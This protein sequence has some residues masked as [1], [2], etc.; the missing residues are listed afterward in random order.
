M[1]MEMLLRGP[2]MI[3]MEINLADKIL[4]MNILL[5]VSKHMFNLMN[6]IISIILRI[7]E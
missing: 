3:K 5:R 1:M 6:I 4:I 7:K 2:F